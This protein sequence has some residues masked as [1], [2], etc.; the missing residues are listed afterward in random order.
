MFKWNSVITNSIQNQNSKKKFKTAA[1][2]TQTSTKN[3][4][5][6]RSHK[7]VSILCWPFTPAGLTSIRIREIKIK[8]RSRFNKFNGRFSVCLDSLGVASKIKHSMFYIYIY[9]DV[10]LHGVFVYRRLENII[11]TVYLYEIFV[12]HRLYFIIYTE[13]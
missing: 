2:Q 3:I 10:Y 13:P 9:I 5:R 7:G 1:R 8:S 11:Y 4:D 6:I 12:N